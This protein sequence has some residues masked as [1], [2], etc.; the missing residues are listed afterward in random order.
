MKYRPDFPDRFGSIEHSR[1]HCVDFFH[2]YNAYHRHS[3]LGMLTPH[4]V[5]HGLA[6]MRHAQRAV[7][8]HPERFVKNL[9]AP[10]ALPA[11][12]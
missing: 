3:G 7:V 12:A 2:W 10:P 6:E 9:P 11:A 5:H 8:L 4:D 1:A